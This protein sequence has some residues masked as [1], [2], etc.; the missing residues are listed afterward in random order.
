MCYSG[1]F[2]RGCLAI[3]P[4]RDRNDACRLLPDLSNRCTQI[5]GWQQ[6]FALCQPQGLF[7]RLLE[8][9]KLLTFGLA[10]GCGWKDATENRESCVPTFSYDARTRG[11]DN[12]E[13]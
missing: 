3:T 11:C 6:G 9:V 8:R 13:D 10:A 12:Q 4:T 7:K 5:L 1:Y 2:S